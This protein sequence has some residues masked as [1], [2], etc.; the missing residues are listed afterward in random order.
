MFYVYQQPFSFI[1]HQLL[2]FLRKEH[3]FDA[4]YRRI[5]PKKNKL[6]HMVLGYYK[7]VNGDLK[8]TKQGRSIYFEPNMCRRVGSKMKSVILYLKMIFVQLFFDNSENNSFFYTYIC[9]YSLSPS[10]SLHC[11]CPITIGE[12]WLSPKLSNISRTNIT[13]L[14]FLIDRQNENN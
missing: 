5:P 1:S 13:L 8:S 4:I 9:F 10:F 11:Y 12:K 14:L 3:E 7:H 2:G 6:Y